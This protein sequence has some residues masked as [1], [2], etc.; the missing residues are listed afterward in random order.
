MADLSRLP[1][2]KRQKKYMKQVKGE[3]MGRKREVEEKSKGQILKPVEYG[4][5]NNAGA[6]F[7]RCF[8]PANCPREGRAKLNE[9]R[10]VHG[11][12]I[13]SV[14][15]QRLPDTFRLYF[16]LSKLKRPT[17]VQCQAWPALLSGNNVVACAPTGSGKTL[18]FLL[19]ALP[20]IAA[21]KPVDSGK[22]QG[23]IALIIS[24]TRELALQIAV[25]AK[26][27]KRKFDVNAVALVGGVGK[28]EQF[29]ALLSGTHI[30]VAT[31]GRLIDILSVGMMSLR[32][33]TYLVLDEA[34]RMLE[35]GFEDQLAQ[36][37][38][39]IRTAC[40]ISLFSATLPK[41]L[42]SLIRNWVAEPRVEIVT[43]GT[44]SGNGDVKMGISPTVT[45]LV[46]VC[47]EHKKSKKLIKFL[48]K[49]RA[50]D[51]E[52]RHLTPVLVFCNKIKTLVYV[53]GFLRKQ[54]FKVGAL[55]GKLPQA[56][57][58]LVLN[59]FKAGKVS[60]MVSTDVAARGLHMKH[61]EVVVN[62]DM[63]SSLEQY[64]HRV[65]RTGRNGEP[66]FAFTFFTRNYSFLAKSL[67]QLLESNGQS[68]DQHL[69]ALTTVGA[70]GSGGGK[71]KKSKPSAKSAEKTEAGEGVLAEPLSYSGGAVNL[72]TL[73]I[74]GNQ[75]DWSS[76]SGDEEG[77]E[78]G[79]SG[80]PQQNKKGK[81]I[82]FAE[83]GALLGVPF[84][85]RCWMAGVQARKKV[86]KATE[87]DPNHRKRKRGKRG[88]K[89]HKK[90]NKPKL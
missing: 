14:T 23:P 5:K 50:D 84:K 52:K 44:F 18:G 40:Q 81:K 61:L 15:D 88:G 31:P 48:T 36:I 77:N 26:S 8:F 76:S 29:D 64:V 7:Q 32:R 33:V 39:Q 45:Q 79:S 90:K 6:P 65:G 70:S 12:K 30:V 27:F 68:V 42:T 82:S 53:E 1:S 63:S 16:K 10:P 34:D 58:T 43:D 66:G 54:D 56:S 38:G 3:F 21:Q 86:E 83:E 87:S 46:Q 49:L 69:K 19:P 25:V 13:D 67:V 47:A 28:E 78:E 2:K 20:H 59:D 72:A 24:P 22:N 89:K 75:S 80:S 62:W 55:H 9:T 4:W 41:R 37:K 73:P 11:V 71:A 60:V 85:D 51:A 57:R 74:N 17:A 35:L